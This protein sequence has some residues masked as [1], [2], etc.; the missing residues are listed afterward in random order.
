LSRIRVLVADDHPVFLEGL[1]TVLE[2]KD[3]S[4]ELVGT[5]SN[6]LEAVALQ[7]KTNAEVV[8]LD[9]KMPEMGG[10]D[11]A[12]AIR[13]RNP[14]TKI[15][16][17]TTFDDRELINSALQ[18]GAHGYLLK[19]AP[20]QEIVKAIKAAHKGSMLMSPRAA[21]K[22]TDIEEDGTEDHI[23]TS[24]VKQLAELTSREREILVLMAKGNDNTSIANELFISEKT[25]RNHV[26]RIYHII[27]V[28]N[29]TQAVIWAFDQGLA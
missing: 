7:E 14:D 6:G 29:R 17:L 23:S 15:I 25:V 2:L 11:A 27:G 28:H 4:I 1:T 16:M 3:P 13:K 9:I 18:A 22:L 19:D 8:L 12:I 20:V 5:A 24:A 26:S 21:E 10:V